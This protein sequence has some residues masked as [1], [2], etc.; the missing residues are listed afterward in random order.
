MILIWRS[1]MTRY[2]VTALVVGLFVA[3]DDAKKDKEQ[4]QG[5]WRPVSAEQGGKAQDDAKEHLLIFDGDTFTIK[6]GD[7]LFLKG[8]FTVDPSQ[9]PK[10]IDMKVT[11]GRR[12][13]HN[14]KGDPRHLRT[15]QGHAQVVYGGAGGQG[16]AQGVRHQRGDQAHAGHAGKG[17]IRQ[18]RTKGS[19][20]L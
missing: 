16:P 10:V 6:K 2:I 5:S 20:V 19:A 1:D 18:K 9:S 11:E 17:E 4:L 8:T 12:D 15:G 3:D 7:Q 14:G 13:E